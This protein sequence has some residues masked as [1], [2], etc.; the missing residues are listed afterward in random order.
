MPTR[1]PSI[2]GPPTNGRLRR[3]SISQRV[4]RLGRQDCR[5]RHRLGAETGLSVAGPGRGGCQGDVVHGEATSD[6]VD[7]GSHGF[8]HSC[9][10]VGRE[11]G[12]RASGGQMV[13]PFVARVVP[14]PFKPPLLGFAEAA[15]SSDTFHSPLEIS[16]LK[17]DGRVPRLAAIGRSILQR[18]VGRH[19]LQDIVE[20]VGD[21][22]RWVED[23]PV[24]RQQPV[25][26]QY[27]CRLAGTQ[28][29]VDP[30]PGLPGDDRVER[31]AAGVP[32]FE[33][34]DLDL[35]PVRLANSAIRAS[36]STP[37][38]V[39]P[40]ALYCRAPMPVPQPTSR[41]STPGLAAMTRCIRASG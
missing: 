41:N 14:L 17:F 10:L 34:A 23:M 36:G 16:L 28:H 38:T 9:E 12:K 3:A 7:G 29:R 11:L 21:F 40:A 37:S 32:I 25:W 31:P 27:L 22:A 2:P 18:R 30:V 6:R 26:P 5:G 39:Q 19:A 33:L 15:G 24:H 1:T 4:F 8:Q 13:Q 35:D 20:G